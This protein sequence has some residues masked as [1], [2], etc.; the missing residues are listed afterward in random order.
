MFNNFENKVSK[1]EL[2]SFV[3]I[4]AF[5]SIVWFFVLDLI[6]KIFIEST[7]V[8]IKVSII[9]GT[10]FL[11]ATLFYL[12]YIIR[13]FEG[14]EKSLLAA[15]YEKEKLYR[16][17]FDLSPVGMMMI[18]PKGNIV[19]ANTE[20]CH[21]TGYSY[22]EIIKKNVR[23]F[24]PLQ[25]K[26]LVKEN[27]ELLMEGHVLN[28]EVRTLKKDNTI[29]YF[30]LLETRIQLPKK[31]TG[32]LIIA[33]DMTEKRKMVEKIK[34]N[35]KLLDTFF[36]S[37]TVGAYIMH[38]EEPV[39]WNKNI[40]NKENLMYVLKNER[41][42]KFNSAIVKLYGIKENILSGM[43]HTDLYENIFENG[44]DY[45][46]ELYD[47][48]KLRLIMRITNDENIS[49]WIEGNYICLYDESGRI[50]GHIGIQY[51]ITEHIN[52][53]DKYFNLLKSF[54]TNRHDS[55]ELLKNSFDELLKKIELMTSE[56]SEMEKDCNEKSLEKKEKIKE[57]RSLSENIGKN[58]V[59]LNTFADLKGNMVK[60]IFSLINLSDV[61]K[62]I[63]ETYRTKANKNNIKYVFQ[64]GIS[65][66]VIDGEKQTIVR[67]ISLLIENAIKNSES[68]EMFV[69]L[70]KDEKL[71]L[72][73]EFEPLNPISKNYSVDIHSD[74]LLT[75]I[76]NEYCNR[77]CIDMSVSKGGESGTKITLLFNNTI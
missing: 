77:N 39:F 73:I 53:R 1:S 31:I 36:N 76:V 48:G 35:Q 42:V 56:I 12:Y 74:K 38:L 59:Y 41:I 75:A 65:E 11:I 19:D 34:D 29:A 72:E 64:N 70:K 16:R 67:L 13:R 40:D 22:A 69:R 44:E 18:D 55:Y 6:A 33:Q 30:N 2:I 21:L 37:S 57:I 50:K 47:E 62:N 10:L 17:I 43:N 26:D 58:I 20:Y 71:Q 8:L 7:E 63:N 66:S 51:D 52:E 49:K 15:I 25:D 45:W 9:K 54:E 4:F 23:D 60:P 14:K 32:I 3:A 68:G 46:Q 28:H 5:S 61:L 27:I 24:V